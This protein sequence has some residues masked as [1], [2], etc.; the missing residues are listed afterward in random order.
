MHRVFLFPGRRLHFLE[1][2]AHHDLDVIAAEPARRAAAIH[3]GVSAAEHDHAAADLVSVSEGDAGEPIDADMDMGA[4]F[5][6]AGELELAPA[7]RAAAD[8][9][10]IIAFG[11]ERF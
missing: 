1:A 5:L 8:E 4:G 11:E 2:R 3:R 7:R 10:R 9:D 6:A